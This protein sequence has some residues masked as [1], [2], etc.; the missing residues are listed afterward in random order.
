MFSVKIYRYNKTDKKA[1]ISNIYFYVIKIYLII[2]GFLLNLKHAKHMYE[3][4][5]RNVYSKRTRQ[6]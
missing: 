5:N 6:I 4:F 1:N 2:V 3:A